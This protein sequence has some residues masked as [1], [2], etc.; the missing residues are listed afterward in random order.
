MPGLGRNAIIAAARA[1]PC[2][3]PSRPSS[4]PLQRIARLKPYFKSG[5]RGIVVAIVTSLLLPATE[6]VLPALMKPLL[7]SGFG[8]GSVPLWMVPVV[9]IGL[10]LVRGAGRLRRPSTG[11]PGRP[12]KACSDLRKAMFERLL[13]AAPRPLHAAHDQQADQHVVYEVQN[14]ATL[15]VSALLTMVRE[16]LTLVA[17]LG[18]LLWLNW[19]LTL[20][21]GVLFPLVAMRVRLISRRMRRITLASQKATDELAYVVEE[22]VLAWRIVRL[23]G[24]ARRQTRALLHSRATCCAGW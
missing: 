24:A 5:N 20:F 6:P 15:L 17:L 11:W 10:F 2:G 3:L 4:S 23:H 13:S 19:Q 18:Y 1:A 14:G 12:T 16:G 8:N 7:D 9:I 22:N 21:V